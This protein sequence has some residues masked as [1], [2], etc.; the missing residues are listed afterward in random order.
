M[1][2]SQSYCAYGRKRTTSG[3]NTNCSSSN[4]LVTD[5][6]FTGQKYDSSGLQFFNARYYDPQIGTFIS[7]DTI[8]PDPGLV[9]DY[10]RYGYAR[11]NA[12]R[13]SDPTGHFSE[14][15]LAFLGIEPEGVSAEAWQ[16]LLALEP[17]D[18]IYGKGV[19]PTVAQIGGTE[20]DGKFVY[21]LYMRTGESY[22]EATTWLS[23]NNSNLGTAMISRWMDDAYQTVWADGQPTAAHLY[24]SIGQSGMLVGPETA[25]KN[26]VIDSLVPSFVGLFLGWVP[27]VGDALGFGYGTYGAL[28]GSSPCPGCAEGDMTMSFAYPDSQR[29]AAAPH[30]RTVW[31]RRGGDDA[32]YLAIDNTWESFSLPNPHPGIGGWTNAR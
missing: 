7:P 18:D 8:V 2:T 4:S 21:R 27:V 17:G 22:S 30:V 14:E 9:I 16:F 26:R 10:N 19:A 28:A 25:A 1:T 32:R 6:T 23:A 11:G 3:G 13:F 12:L 24:H 31:F 5:H 15:Q 20:I 29:G